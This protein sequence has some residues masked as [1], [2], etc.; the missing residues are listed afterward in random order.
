MGKA[1]DRPPKL[2]Q[3]KRQSANKDAPPSGY[4][5]MGLREGD[6]VVTVRPMRARFPDDTLHHRHGVFFR[7]GQRLIAQ[8]FVKG[9]E[10]VVS[11]PNARGKVWVRLVDVKPDRPVP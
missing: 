4:H 1:N 2:R 10:L 5:P 8:T 11:V 3:I 9:G 7:R 6:T